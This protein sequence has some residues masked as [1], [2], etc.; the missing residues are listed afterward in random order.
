MSAH[1]TAIQRYQVVRRLA[2]GGM[3]AL[4]LAWDPALKRQVAIKLMHDEDELR[5]RFAREARRRPPPPPQHRHHLRRRR[6]DGRPFIAM[7]YIHGETLAEVVRDTR[8]R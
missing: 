8:R 5:E 4:Y 3:G 7:E 2:Q 1:P 6:S